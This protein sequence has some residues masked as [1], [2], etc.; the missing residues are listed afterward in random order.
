MPRINKYYDTEITYQLQTFETILECGKCRENGL[1]L[2]TEKITATGRIVHACT[3]C[4]REVEVQGE[5]YP[6]KTTRRVPVSTIAIERIEELPDKHPD[7]YDLTEIHCLSPE[8]KAARLLSTTNPG[9]VDSLERSTRDHLH[10]PT[11]AVLRTALYD[12][13]R[14]A[15]VLRPALPQQ[16]AELTPEAVAS[17]GGSQMISLLYSTR[18]P[19]IVDAIQQATENRL[20]VTAGMRQA[21]YKVAKE[22]VMLQASQPEQTLLP[23]AVPAKNK[24]GRPR[25]H[26]LPVA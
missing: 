7:E 5:A 13:A 21:L 12:M 23:P 18:S 6:R 20:A 25:K 2:P 17:L 11:Y 22:A 4:H 19:Q 8:R 9:Q 16:E 26:P 14:R 1:M 15:A 10:K 3:N 24:G